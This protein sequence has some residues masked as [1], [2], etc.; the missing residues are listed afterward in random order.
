MN[1]ADAPKSVEAYTVAWIAALFHERAAEKAVF[2]EE[3][4]E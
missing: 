2:G 1:Q 4:R 3:Y